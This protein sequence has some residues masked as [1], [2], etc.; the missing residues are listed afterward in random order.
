M[1][2]LKH[3]NKGV[4]RAYLV[5]LVIVLSLTLVAVGVLRGCLCRG[6]TCIVVIVLLLSC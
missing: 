4:N 1:K 5:S 3:R 6:L 2:T